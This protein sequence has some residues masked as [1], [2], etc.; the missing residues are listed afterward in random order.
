MTNEEL[1]RRAQDFHDTECGKDIAAFADYVIQQ[2]EEHGNILAAV[3]PNMHTVMALMANMMPLP[4]AV[5]MR[6]LAI[7]Y[8]DNPDKAAE[9][10][11]QVAP[12]LSAA[13]PK[14]R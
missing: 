7:Y 14:G 2:V 11:D 8:Y 12:F 4:F 3:P 13:L 5:I 9:A 1:Y 10:Y 6:T